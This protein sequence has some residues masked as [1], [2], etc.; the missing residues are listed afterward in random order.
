M[1]SVKQMPATKTFSGKKYDLVAE[2][3]ETRAAVEKAAKFYAPMYLT[4]IVPTQ[5]KGLNA[6]YYALYARERK[7]PKK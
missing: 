4:K 3:F 5:Y 7:V 6:R 1:F 2:M